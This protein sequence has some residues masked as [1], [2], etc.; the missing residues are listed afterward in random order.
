MGGVT[1]INRQIVASLGI[2]DAD[3]QRVIKKEVWFTSCG[4]GGD[5]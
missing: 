1:Y 5:T 2:S 4:L 3:V